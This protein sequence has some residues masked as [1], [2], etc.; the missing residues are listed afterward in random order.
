MLIKIFI[1]IC[2]SLYRDERLKIFIVPPVSFKV[3]LN[4]KFFQ[5]FI[6]A[7]EGKKKK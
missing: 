1:K 4:L 7:D 6:V 5:I 2:I 3:L